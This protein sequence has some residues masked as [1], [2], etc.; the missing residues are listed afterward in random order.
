MQ[1]T[2]AEGGALTW[3]NK[4]SEKTPHTVTEKLSIA[5]SARALVARGWTQEHYARDAQNLYVGPRDESATRWCIVGAVSASGCAPALHDEVLK[6][7]R[8]LLGR[9]LTAWNDQRERTQGDVL[10]VMD[11][12]IDSYEKG[13]DIVPKAMKHVDGMEWDDD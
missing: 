5:R 7:A 9:P 2:D 3:V 4:G 12:L 10:A 1:C 13:R 6:D 11:Q 8:A